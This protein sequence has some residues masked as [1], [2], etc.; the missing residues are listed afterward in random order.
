LEVTLALLKEALFL[1][2]VFVASD[3]HSVYDADM[4]APVSLARASV[5]IAVA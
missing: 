2:A 3:M 1:E 5:Y 4:Q